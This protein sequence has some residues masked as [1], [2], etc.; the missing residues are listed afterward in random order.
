MT[1][2]NLESTPLRL[3]SSEYRIPETPKR[4]QVLEELNSKITKEKLIKKNKK[5]ELKMKIL[6]S[7]RGGSSYRKV[8]VQRYDSAKR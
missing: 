2:G 8:S 4:D 5:D 7:V 3:N 6:S 1:W